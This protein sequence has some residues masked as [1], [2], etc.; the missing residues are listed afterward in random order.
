MTPNSE[1]YARRVT[2]HALRE[3]LGRLP[4]DEEFN[5]ALVVVLEAV[6]KIKELT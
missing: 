6:A 2:S 5:Q 3:K 4:T 1:K